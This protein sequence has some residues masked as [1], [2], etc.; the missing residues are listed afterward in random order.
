MVAW[1]K[2]NR[3]GKKLARVV[4]SNLPT[5][6]LPLFL[7]TDTHIGIPA[8]GELE[9]ISSWEDVIHFI[10]DGRFM[11]GRTR[12]RW[13][14]PF[15]RPRCVPVADIVSARPSMLRH[16]DYQ[17]ALA[18]A[19]PARCSECGTIDHSV[20]KNLKAQRRA[21]A[22]DLVRLHAKVGADIRTLKIRR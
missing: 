4:A 8:R 10:P 22:R 16:I 18:T 3:L 11:T 5:I 1:F 21:L 17:I 7:Q 12:V 6:H 20:V 13:V 19:Q 14:N 2:K 9:S 15:K